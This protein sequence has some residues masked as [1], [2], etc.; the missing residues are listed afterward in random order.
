MSSVASYRRDETG[1]VHLGLHLSAEEYRALTTALYLD[2]SN[3]AERVR[4][5]LALAK[6]QFERRQNAEPADITDADAPPV[7]DQ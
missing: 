6:E 4:L 2:P 7:G 5:M 3:A 1:V